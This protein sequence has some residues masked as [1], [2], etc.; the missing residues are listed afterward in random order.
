VLLCLPLGA[1]F[2]PRPAFPLSLVAPL[3]ALWLGIGVV[4]ALYLRAQRPAVL[5]NGERLCV[6]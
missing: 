1:Q 2:Y 5:R 3:S 6:L 4:V